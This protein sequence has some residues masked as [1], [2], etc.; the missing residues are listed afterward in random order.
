MNVTLLET[1]VRC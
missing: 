1:Y